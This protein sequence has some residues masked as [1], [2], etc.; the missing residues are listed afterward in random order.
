MNLVGCA[1]ER[2][3][4]W[5]A[6]GIVVSFARDAIKIPTNVVREENRV[7]SGIFCRV[8]HVHLI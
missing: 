4:S 5:C 8:S 3:F 7:I 1:G 2:W 6:G